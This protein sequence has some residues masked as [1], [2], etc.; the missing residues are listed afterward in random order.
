MLATLPA[1]SLTFGLPDPGDIAALQHVGTHVLASVTSPE[2]ARAAHQAGVDGLVVQGPDA[3]GH[4]ATHDPTRV[5]EPIRTED[6]VARVRAA[7]EL[8]MVAC[9]GVDGPD[10]VARLLAAGAQSVAAGTLLLRTDEAGTSATHRDALTDPALTETV[11]TRSFTGRPARALRNGFIDRHEAHAPTSYPAVHHL[12]RDLRRTAG[13][14]GDTDLVHL[15][16]GTGY[17]STRTGP[18]ADVIRWLAEAS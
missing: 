15:W 13:E 2:E 10:A 12:T 11:M 16:A 3:G 9:G 17:R 8:P 6:L 18:A 7:V 1:V 5:P 14:A 4:S